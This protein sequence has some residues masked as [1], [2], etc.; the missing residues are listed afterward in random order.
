M[1]KLLIC[2]SLLTLIGCSNTY[3]PF[4]AE[5]KAGDCIRLENKDKESWEKADNDIK[6]ILEVG[7]EKYNIQYASGILKGQE[8]P[9]NYIR[10][11]DSIFKKT[12]CPNE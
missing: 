10:L 1:K 11:V 8:S 3:N 6:K 4:K 12:E 2:T 7:K 5:F 9:F